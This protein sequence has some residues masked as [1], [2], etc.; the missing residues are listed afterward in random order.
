M[1]AMVLYC[2]TF[3]PAYK[4]VIG[5]LRV[6]WELAAVSRRVIDV[7]TRRK[8]LQAVKSLRCIGLKV[9]HFHEIQRN[10]SVVFVNFV[11]RQLVRFLVAF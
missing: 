11:E 6:R 9:G 2:G 1:A 7:N 5:Q 8:L 3:Q 4:L 10:S